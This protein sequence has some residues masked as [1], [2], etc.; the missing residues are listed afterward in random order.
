MGGAGG[1]RI[2]IDTVRGTCQV[3]PFTIR[4]TQTLKRSLHQTMKMTFIILALLVVCGLFYA[5]STQKKNAAKNE[6]NISTASN[7]K[8]PETAP[9]DNPYEALKA[10]AYSVQYGEL[11]LPDP[12]VKEVLYG[13]LMDWDYSEE[14]IVTVV[15]FMTGDASL[16]ISTG[17]IIIGGGQHENVNAKSKA[18]VENASALLPMANKIDTALTSEKGFLKFYLLTNKGKYTIKDKME[19]IRNHTSPLSSMFTEAD[20]LITQ[21]R[22]TTERLEQ[23]GSNN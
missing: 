9:E 4:N 21:I 10:R 17:A 22:L 19:N 14:A 20:E 16:Y 13:V 5:L 11:G 1:G 6:S 3:Q 23:Q 7:V 2:A 8:S 12:G 15:S 18:F